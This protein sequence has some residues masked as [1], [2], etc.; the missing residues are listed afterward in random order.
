MTWFSGWKRQ[1]PPSEPMERDAWTRHVAKLAAQGI[2]EPGIGRIKPVTEAD[3]NTFYDTAPSF[4]DRLPW[5]EFLPQSNCMLLEDGLSVAAFFEI[6]PLGT[7]GRESAWL[8]Q[9]RD[10]LENILQDSFDELDQN[11]WVVQLYAQDE[12][13]WEAYLHTLRQYVQPRARGSAFSTFYQRFFAHHLNAIAKPGGLFED[14][15]LTR[16]PWKGQIRRV[17]MVVY[18]RAPNATSLKRGQSAEQALSNVCDRLTAGLTGT[19]IKTCRLEAKDIH[20]WLLRWFNP[21]P[22]LLGSTTQDRERFYNLTAYPT[23]TNAGEI[24]LASGTD[25]SQRLFYNQ[26]H[27]DAAQGIWYFDGMPHRVMMMDRL[28][29]VPHT[30]HLTG[31]TR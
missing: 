26:P 1:E 29:T 25:F 31:E 6:T 15:T 30:G 9:A 28:R 16:L 11:P 18:R 24:E 19:G 22:S 2:A 4:V 13:N 21:A 10:T 20:D 8:Q 3:D 23:E 27:S 14:T 17:R 5:V 12:T 7:E